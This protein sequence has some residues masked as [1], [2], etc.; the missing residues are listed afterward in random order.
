[1]PPRRQPY[2]HG[3]RTNMAN[4]SQLLKTN[5]GDPVQVIREVLSNAA[6]A[7]ARN[8]WLAPLPFTKELAGFIIADD[9]TGMSSPIQDGSSSGEAEADAKRKPV[10]CNVS[11]PK[12]ADIACG[13]VLNWCS[14]VCRA[15]TLGFIPFWTSQT[16]RRILPTVLASWAL[17]ASCCGMRKSVCWW[18]PSQLERTRSCTLLST[19]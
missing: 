12:F 17:E 1:M 3:T 13:A 16:P 11:S 15:N 8:V 2:S 10:D 14:M 4:L 19:C 7:H 9:G 5:A 6:D 18:P